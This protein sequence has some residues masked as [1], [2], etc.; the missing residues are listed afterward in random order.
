MPEPP[1]PEPPKKSEKKQFGFSLLAPPKPKNDP[2]KYKNLVET[3]NVEVKRFKL[4]SVLT[5]K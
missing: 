4:H 1:K 3:L 5:S 2:V